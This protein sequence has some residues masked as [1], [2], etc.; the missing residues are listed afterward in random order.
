MERVEGFG[1]FFFAAKDPKALAE[2]YHGH[3]GILPVPGDYETPCWRQDAGETVFAPFG[4][5]TDPVGGAER[6]FGHRF[7]VTEEMLDY[8]ERG[9]A[10]K[11]AMTQL[12]AIAAG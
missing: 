8:S 10:F 7:V 3:L 5:V 11:A 12:E 4:R 6:P 2:W 1:G 9:D